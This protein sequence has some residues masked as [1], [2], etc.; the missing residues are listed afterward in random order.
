MEELSQFMSLVSAESQ[1]VQKIKEEKQKRLTPKIDVNKSLGDFFAI[2][3]EAKSVSSIIEAP[4]ASEKFEFFPKNLHNRITLPQPPVD[5]QKEIVKLKTIIAK[6][7]SDDEQSIRDHDEHAFY[8]IDMYCK[9]HGLIFHDDEMNDIVSQAKPTIKYFK[10]M[11]DVARPHVIDPSIKPMSS[12]TNK[13][14]AY[15]SGHACQ[16]MLVGLYVS[17]KFPEHEEGIIE[18]AKE[19]GMG[20]VQAGFHYLADYVAGNL[21]A[22]KMFLVMNKDNYG[23]YLNEAPR[24][25][26]KKGQPA[27]SDKHSDLYT[28]ENPKGT[29]QGLGFKDVETA[30]ASVSKIENSGK[31][32]A[33]KIQAAIAMEQ[34]AKVMGKKAEAAVYRSYIEKMKKKT[35]E[36]NKEDYTH[37]PTQVDPKKDKSDGWIVGDPTQPIIFD[38]GDTKDILDKANR[39]IERERQVVQ[40]PFIGE[41][42]NAQ[43]IDVLKTFFNRL[44]KFEETINQRELAQKMKQYMPEQKERNELTELKEQFNHFRNLVSRQMSTIGG[45]GAVNLLDL[46]DID[47]S[48]LGNG[49]FLV[50]NSTTGKLEFT[51]QVDGN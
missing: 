44:D 49:K 15:P 33:H 21:L 20:R 25:P 1:K 41:E 14:P 16:S 13:T 26:R 19:C 47:T 43:R 30:K 5:L 3:S 36:M 31:T 9:K 40:K 6:R 42:V 11:F 27:G 34:R 35:K 7:T 50:Y 46:D 17:S 2:I 18:A 10:E 37:Y 32:H 4:R 24:I 22:E 8:A 39:D 51:D 23:D 29:I 38:G 12:T 48:S 28:D 45:G